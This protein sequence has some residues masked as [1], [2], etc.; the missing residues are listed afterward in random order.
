MS[1]F[2]T[3]T[4]P[5]I[6][7]CLGRQLT[8]VE[9]VRHQSIDAMSVEQLEL[10]KWLRRRQLVLCALYVMFISGQTLKLITWHMAE[11][12]IEDEQNDTRGRA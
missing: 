7:A 11:W 6:E 5:Q 2:S 8:D 4:K 12:E 9:L 3:D 1:N 10:A